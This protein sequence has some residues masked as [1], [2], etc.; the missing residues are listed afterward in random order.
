MKI[1]GKYINYLK[2]AFI[3]T[4][5]HKIILSFIKYSSMVSNCLKGIDVKLSLSFFFQ[6]HFRNNS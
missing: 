5:N 1:E 4:Y 6:K 3:K 2:F